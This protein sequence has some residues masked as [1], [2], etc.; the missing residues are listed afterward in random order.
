[1]N[2]IQQQKDYYEKYWTTGH[3]QFSGDHQ[4]YA[5]NLRSWMRAELRDIT[6]DTPILE[7]G[8]GDGSFTRSLGVLS[9]RVTAVD[10]SASQIE[11]NSRS[12]PE[13]KFIQHDVA[14]PFP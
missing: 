12:Q 7:V 6:D 13:I 8:C 14:Q 1:M 4:G 3:D 10:I 11:R 2:A 9:S 5:R